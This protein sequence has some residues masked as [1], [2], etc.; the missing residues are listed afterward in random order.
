M[1]R[2]G[3]PAFHEE[4][5][6]LWGRGDALKT[7]SA[8]GS[9]AAR[10]ELATFRPPADKQWVSMRPWAS[11]S[12]DASA[13]VD[14]VDAWDATA[15]TKAVPRGGCCASLGARNAGQPPWITRIAPLSQC[16]KA[17]AKG[18]G[19]EKSLAIALGEKRQERPA[20]Q[21]SPFRPQ[22]ASQTPQSRRSLVTRRRSGAASDLASR[23][24]LVPAQRA[25]APSIGFAGRAR[26]R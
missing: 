14:G 24:P 2:S 9:R 6:L 18:S 10:F 12:S 13:L 1:G 8:T 5:Q 17:V 15:D 11:R 19:W 26:R 20:A 25:P 22:R 16:V 4:R 21:T 23:D 7:S 3:V